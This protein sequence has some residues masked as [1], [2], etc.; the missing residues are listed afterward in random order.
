MP[1]VGK[2]VEALVETTEVAQVA[3]VAKMA[4]LTEVEGAR[5]VGKIGEET[6]VEPTVEVNEGG[7]VR[8]GS[9][10]IRNKVASKK[11]PTQFQVWLC[12]SLLSKF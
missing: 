3:E 10:P 7:A 8:D 2:P 12:C 11:I 1:F 5:E 9:A 6:V 4:V